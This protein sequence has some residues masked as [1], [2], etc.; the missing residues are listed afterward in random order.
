MGSCTHNLSVLDIDSLPDDVG[1]HKHVPLILDELIAGV[2]AP[3][4]L[5]ALYTRMIESVSQIDGK[6][7]LDAAFD[8]A[9]DAR[10]EID[11]KIAERH[12]R[13]IGGEI[14]NYSFFGTDS[15][16]GPAA[17]IYSLMDKCELLDRRR[18]LHYARRCVVDYPI[19]RMEGPVH[20]NVVE[21]MNQ[22]RRVAAALAA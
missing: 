3:P 21:T 4:L 17:I 10:L 5:N 22:S 7:D 8:C 6:S 20:W 15:G 18:Y 16:G 19:N 14:C 1:R 9:Q 2:S 13:R 12:M 11:N